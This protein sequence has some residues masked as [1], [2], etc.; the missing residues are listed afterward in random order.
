MA[1]HDRQAEQAR[2][3]AFLATHRRDGDP[4]QAPEKLL[5]LLRG[6]HPTPIAARDAV[7]VTGMSEFWLHELMTTWARA[8]RLEHVGYGAYVLREDS[9]VAA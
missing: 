4:T 1:P 3:A 7:S 2:R 9:L 8:G 6:S 5:G